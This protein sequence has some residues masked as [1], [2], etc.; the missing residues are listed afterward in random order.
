[1][2]TPSSLMLIAPTTSMAVVKSYAS[3]VRPVV[4]AQDDAV[5]SFDSAVPCLLTTYDFRDIP[6]RVGVAR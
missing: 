1:M 3:E 5:N 2:A 6:I 4:S